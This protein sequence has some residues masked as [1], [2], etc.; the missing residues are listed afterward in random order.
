MI[1]RNDLIQEYVKEYSDKSRVYFI[2]N[3]FSTFDGTEGRNVPF[4]LFPKQREYCQAI[5]DSN[6][7]VTVKHRQCGISTVSCAWI[8]AE[9]ALL[10]PNSTF[11]VLCI[12]NKL[13]QA[14][15]LLVKIRTFLEQ[16]PRY[17]F[18]DDYYSDDPKSE[19]NKRDIFLKNSKTQLT[20][21]N[22]GAVY[23]R[24]ASANAARGISSVSVVIFDEAAFILDAMD[25]YASAVATTSAVKDS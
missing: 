15:E 7:I 8:A 20:L 25:T 16:V 23:A 18:G 11:T 14:Q 17:Y 2:E 9:L 5:A 10:K 21:V 12:A 3:H 6:K 22:G 24:A 19:K 13:E 1:D 4:M